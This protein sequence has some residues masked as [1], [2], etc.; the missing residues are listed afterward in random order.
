[1]ERVVLGAP[2]RQG[3]EKERKFTMIEQE[4]DME[5]KHE[6]RIHIDQKPYESPNP[7]TGK[8][9]YVLGKIQEDFELYREV[10]GDEEDKP[11]HDGAEEI[12]LKEDEHFHSAPRRNETFTV[13]V[14]GRPKTVMQRELSFAEI[15][16]LAF[17][18]FPIGPNW[19]FTVTY[20]NAAGKPHE[21]TL[22]DGQTIE[23]KKDGT[24]FNATATDKS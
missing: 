21:G 20:R 14:N 17:N 18:P 15:V 8:A 16:A 2:P 12:R 13:I 6:M 7:T 1:V 11:V 22:I 24:I 10:R 19:A 3:E 23:I 5:S 9:L 4:T